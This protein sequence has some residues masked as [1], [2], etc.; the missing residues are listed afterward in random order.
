MPFRDARIPRRL[1]GLFGAGFAEHSPPVRTPAVRLISDQ[2]LRSVRLPV[3]VLLAGNTV[4]LWP[5]ASHA[6][7]IELPGEVN[8]FIHRFVI[9]HHPRARPE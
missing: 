6:L 3:Q 2:V 7:P 4:H 1:D 9:H 8:G 5:N